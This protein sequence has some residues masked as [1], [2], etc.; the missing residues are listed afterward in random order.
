[1]LSDDIQGQRSSAQILIYF[2]DGRGE[3]GRGVYA[4]GVE[5]EDFYRLAGY[6]GI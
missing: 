3:D 6:H 2:V 1:M 5:E 4:R